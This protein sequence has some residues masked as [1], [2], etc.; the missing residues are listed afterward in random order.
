MPVHGAFRVGRPLPSLARSYRRQL[1]TQI[2]YSDPDDPDYTELS[3]Y[4][5]RESI[6]TYP[7]GRAI[8]G[9]P[10]SASTIAS[11]PSAARTVKPLRAGTAASTPVPQAARYSCG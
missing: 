6:T 9:N 5:D 10:V 4:V 8:R 7:P 11:V 2:P 3:G 1:W